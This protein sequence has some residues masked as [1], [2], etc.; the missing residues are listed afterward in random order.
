MDQYRAVFSKVEEDTSKLLDQISQHLKDYVDV[1]QKGFEGLITVC[2]P[3][4]WPA[5]NASR[6]AV[7]GQDAIMGDTP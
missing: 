6:C 3:R 1:S 5:G 4:T 7:F 2:K